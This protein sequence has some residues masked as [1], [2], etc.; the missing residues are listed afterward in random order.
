[1][2]KN[3]YQELNQIE[4]SAKKQ[5]NHFQEDLFP[6]LENHQRANSDPIPEICITSNSNSDNDDNSNGKYIKKDSNVSQGNIPNSQ[7]K[8]YNKNKTNETSESNLINKQISA[9]F[10]N[11]NIYGFKGRSPYA[12][13]NINNMI[14]NYSNNNTG[15]NSKTNSNKS[16]KNNSKTNLNYGSKSQKRNEPALV[17]QLKDKVLEYR[18]SICN[19]VAT[20]SEDLHKHLSLKKHYTLPKKI[21]K[22]KKAKIF[23]KSS[24]KLNQTF[25]YSM[26]RIN[27]K[28]YFCKFCTKKFD[29]ALG[30]NAHLNAHRYKCDFCHKLFNSKDDLI[31]HNHNSEFYYENKKINIY[32]K[33]VY[34]SPGKR[35]K[36]EIDDWEE[37]SSNKK[38]KWDSEEET[39]K[40]DFEQSYTFLG[41]NEDNFDFNKM[42]KIDAK[43]K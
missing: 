20:E 5:S 10:I 36:T 9:D 33:K 39:S 26:C 21:K 3:I 35:I 32:K 29:S 42:I 4:K 24:N 14:I 34:K 40:Y 19:F 15:K 6:I 30:L 22:G 28:N 37:I 16:N 11:K 18:C 8:D 38:E 17:T 2:Q 43:Q 41:D 1:M 13:P 12:N 25:I 31:R 27:K 7:Q 23:F